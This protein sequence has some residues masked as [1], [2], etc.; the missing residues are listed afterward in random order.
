FDS[1]FI[2]PMKSMAFCHS[3]IN[4]NARRFGG[5]KLSLHS[6]SEKFSVY[7]ILAEETEGLYHVKT[8]G[9]SW[10][11]A[12]RVVALKNPELFCEIYDY[13]LSIFEHD[14]KSYSLVTKISSI[15]KIDNIPKE[16]LP[17]LLNLTECRQMIHVSFGSILSKKNDKYIF[18]DRIC[19][20]LFENESLHYEYV[21]EN[22]KKHLELLSI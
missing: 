20:T 16:K 17:D 8:C 12:V 1:S 14:R 9:T 4:R 11:E 6:G 3:P 13:A 22:I 21:R 10:L 5:Y 7:K 2:S 15:P 19:R 18:K